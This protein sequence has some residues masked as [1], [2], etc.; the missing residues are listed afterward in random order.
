MTQSVPNGFSFSELEAML[1][2]APTDIVDQKPEC[3]FCSSDNSDVD[4]LWDTVSKALE[5]FEEVADGPLAAKGAVVVIIN[6]MIEWHSSIAKKMIEA[7]EVESAIGWARDAGKF[8]AIANIITTVQ[9]TDDD[10]IN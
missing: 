5:A 6:R 7:G 2:N 8:Q 4:E 9:V 3:E 10:P 1:E